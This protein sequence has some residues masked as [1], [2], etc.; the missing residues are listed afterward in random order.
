MDDQHCWSPDGR[1][2]AFT[3]WA[4]GTLC[5]VYVVAPDGT[6]LTPV[7][8]ACPR[9][10]NEQTC[11]G[12]ANASF[13]LD[14]KQIAFTRSRGAVKS[15]PRTEDRIEHSALAMMSRGGAGRRVVYQG[16]AFSGDL[17]FPVFSP[18]GGSSCSSGTCPA[19]PDSRREAFRVL[20]G[21]ARGPRDRTSLVP[22]GAPVASAAIAQTVGSA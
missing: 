20:P 12:E 11:S 3:G 21:A 5:H 15:E 6:G 7:G 16:P 2:I 22:R 13:S 4:S 9:G 17:D 18:D 14:S 1:Q 8:D 10:A 19:P